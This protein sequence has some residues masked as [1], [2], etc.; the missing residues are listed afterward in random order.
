MVA[1]NLSGALAHGTEVEVTCVSTVPG[2]PETKW[3]DK[4]DLGE[5][6]KFIR[7]QRLRP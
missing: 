5:V 2:S 4:Q 3:P 1:D 6:T 7:K